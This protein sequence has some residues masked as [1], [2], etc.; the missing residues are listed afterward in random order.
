MVSIYRQG[1]LSA[2]ILPKSRSTVAWNP[3]PNA[4]SPDEK[5]SDNLRSWEAAMSDMNDPDHWQQWDSGPPWA[6]CYSQLLRPSE[7]WT[8]RN[9]TRHLDENP[10][11]DYGYG[12]VE[13]EFLSHKCIRWG[14]DT[15]LGAS[16]RHHRRGWLETRR[17]LFYSSKAIKMISLGMHVRRDESL[18]FSNA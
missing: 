6:D 13:L 1:R 3:A 4:K 15:I 11:L 18:V 2:L 14:K 16:C 12:R 5:G 17:I 10:T 7:G 8:I 9:A